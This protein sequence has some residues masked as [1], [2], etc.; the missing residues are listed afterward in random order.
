M[1]YGRSASGPA[2]QSHFDDAWASAATYRMRP[3]SLLAEIGPADARHEIVPPVVIIH[4]DWDEPR[5]RFTLPPK[6][7]AI[8]A[9]RL[10]LED[11]TI[12]EG[13]IAI[14][15]IAVHGGLALPRGLPW[16]TTA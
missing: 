6:C 14:G 9:W 4:D 1:I 11:S 10:V 3:S 13:K 8:S 5:V 15:Q 7:A 2:C 12:R 16:G